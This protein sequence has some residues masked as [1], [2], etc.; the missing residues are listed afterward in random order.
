MRY[1]KKQIL[2]W[3]KRYK[4]GKPIKTPEGVGRDV[5]LDAWQT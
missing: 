1:E 5:F 4:A 2:R 3:V